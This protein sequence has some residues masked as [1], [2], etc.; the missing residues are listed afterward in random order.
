[1]RLSGRSIE[2]S[3]LKG[4]VTVLYFWATWCPPCWQEFPKVEKLYERYESNHNVVFLAIDAG[5]ESQTA[6][7]ARSFIENGAYR[8]PAA[9]DDRRAAAT[10]HIRTLP[11]LL[12]L[13]KAWH[14]RLVH[15]GYDGSEHFIANMSKVIDQLVEQSQQ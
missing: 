4:T 11:C 2:S 6:E 14:V 8:I 10:L 13:D 3:R 15:V 1:M 12:L 7:T 9:F 5:E